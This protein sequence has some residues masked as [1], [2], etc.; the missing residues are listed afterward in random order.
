[1]AK[2][3]ISLLEANPALAAEWHPTKNIGQSPDTL[4]ANS[5]YNAWWLGH[6]GHEWQ[7]VVYSRNRGTGCPFCTNQ[8]LLKGFNDLSTIAPDAALEWHPTKNGDLTPASVLA[9][10]IKD[11]V[12]LGKCGHEWSATVVHRTKGSGCPYCNN[13]TVLKGYNDLATTHPN[14]AAEWHP[15]KNSFAPD[16]VTFGSQ[17]KV[18]WLGKC[19]HEWS[20]TIGSRAIG[21]YDCPY[22]AN[23]KLLK[24]FN[25]FAT[26]Y[27]DITKEWHPSKNLPLEPTDFMIGSQKLWWKCCCCGHEWQALA[28]NRVAGSG[29]PRCANKRKGKH[30]EDTK[31]SV[32]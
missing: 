19:G 30:S 28:K 25:D 10:T 22:C 16:T 13:V 14:L 12:W 11:A 18:W 6:C 31:Q 20:A 24:G 5:A 27:P 32:P 3:F 17:K 21:K 23:K 1:M 15:A 29:C 4:K 2:P 26:R 8:K 7:A 9:Y